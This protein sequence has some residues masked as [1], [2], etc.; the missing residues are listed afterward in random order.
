MMLMPYE[1]HVTLPRNYYEYLMKLYERD[2][3]Q[4]V[5][6]T[7]TD[8]EG[9]VGQCQKCK[10]ALSN[11]YKEVNFCNKCGKMVFW[12]NSKE[13]PKKLING[14]CQ[15][16]GKEPCADGDFCHNC[17]QRINWGDK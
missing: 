1:K 6:K 9:S 4:Y 7:F 12:G 17:G 2:F 5:V 16:C 11:K 13:K 14:R 15:T 8:D 3:A 10:E